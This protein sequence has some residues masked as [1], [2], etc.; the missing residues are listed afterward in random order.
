MRSRHNAEFTSLYPTP[1]AQLGFYPTLATSPQKIVPP[2]SPLMQSIP[3]VQWHFNSVTPARF[4][5]ALS[6]HTLMHSPPSRVAFVFPTL[7]VGFFCSHRLSV[8]L[9]ARSFI[10]PLSLSFSLSVLLSVRPL[11]STPSGIWCGSWGERHVLQ[12]LG[13]T[14]REF[15]A[16]F[17]PAPLP[18]GSHL[19]LIRE[20][21]RANT[22]V[23]N[24]FS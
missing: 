24:S 7:C 8:P 19:S 11:F 15:P 14:W 10:P 16:S 4:D 12:C 3:W 17:S 18:R 22:H 9:L 5:V 13:R 23:Q 6:S 1:P 21:E 20:Q 2:C